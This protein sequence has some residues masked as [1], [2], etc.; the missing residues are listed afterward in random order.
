MRDHA[1]IL[2]VQSL[3]KLRVVI[4]KIA[5]LF[6]LVILDDDGE[7]RCRCELDLSLE[8]PPKMMMPA[9]DELAVSTRS[10]ET[11]SYTHTSRRFSSVVTMFGLP[12]SST[13]CEAGM[14]TLISP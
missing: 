7:V 1:R 9:N 3:L 8:L 4:G 12:S 6:L 11:L 2:R 10:V 5:D 13:T 14:P